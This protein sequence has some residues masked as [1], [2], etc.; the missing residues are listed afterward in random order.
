TGM[1]NAVVRVDYTWI[2][3]ASRSQV[4]GMSVRVLAPEELIASKIFV[5]R[6]ERFDG[7]DICH[8]IYGTR[9]QFDWQHLLGLI[10]EQWDMLFWCLVL[11]HYVYPANSDY[12]PGEIWS[13]L[14][15]RFKVELKHPNKSIDFRGSLIDDKMFAIDVSE[16]G[17]RNVLEEYRGK[18]E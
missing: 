8:V 7:A 15:Q 11:Y 13:E 9:G 6:R 1:S 2:R 4:Y 16:W 18:A 14:L 5:T 3:H 17:K 12:V 10:G